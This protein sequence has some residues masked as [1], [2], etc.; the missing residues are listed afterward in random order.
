MGEPDTFVDVLVRNPE[1]V[2]RHLNEC[3]ERRGV[4]FELRLRTF[5][6]Q[7]KYEEARQPARETRRFAKS[8]LEGDTCVLSGIG[9]T[10]SHGEQPSSM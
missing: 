9:H 7:A 8:M 1:T 6:V 4:K 2:I 3:L 10:D 5:D